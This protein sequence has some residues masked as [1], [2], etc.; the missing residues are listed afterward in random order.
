MEHF[1]Q[2]CEEHQF[3]PD[4]QS[5]YRQGYST[6]TSLIKMMNDIPW[7]MER[8]EITAVIILDMSAAFDTVDHNLLLTI[9]QNRYGITDTALQWF[10]SYLRPCGMR[11]CIDNVYSSIIALNYSV[12]QGSVS[13]ANLFLAY[14][15][16]IESVVPA[17]ITINGFAD[18]H[19]I[20][21]FITDGR[22]QELQLILMLMDTVTTIASWMDTVHLKLNPDMIEFIM[23]GNRSH[24]VKCT[25]NCVN[26]SDRTIPRSQSVKYLDVTLDENLSLKEHILL[27][28]RKA[29]ANFVMTCNI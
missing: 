8:K 3:L 17:G 14:C 5:A 1:N 13:G 16:L 11:V 10:Q 4:F 21:S 6:E 27:K 26:I 2:H 22:D 23:F 15:A 28:C 12:P 24:P 29:I 19:S 20:R 9:H 18:D 7:G 25:T